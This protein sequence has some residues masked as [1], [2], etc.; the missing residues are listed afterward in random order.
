MRPI[1]DRDYFGAFHDHPFITNT[2]RANAADLLERVNKLLTMAER[3]G[4]SL[5]VNPITGTL[6]SGNRN[7][8]WRLPNAVVGSPRSAHKEAR[9]VDVYDPHDGDLDDWCLENLALLESLG[10]YLEHPAATKGWCHL[11]TRPPRSGRRVFYP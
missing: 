5:E 11:S 3:A 8:G 2:H 4:V 1:T 6:V 7:G 9:A 10:L